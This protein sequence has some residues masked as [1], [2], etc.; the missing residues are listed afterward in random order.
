MNAKKNPK[1][2]LENKKS[3]FFQTGIILAMALSLAAFQWKV[4][5]RLIVELPNNIVTLHDDD[6]IEITI[7]KPPP[8]PPVQPSTELIITP[9]APDDEPVLF[10]PEIDIHDIVEHRPA[11]IVPTIVEPTEPEPTWFV[12]IKPEYPGGDAALFRYFGE[13]IRYPVL[14]RETG[15]KGTVFIQFVIERDGSVTNVQIMKG[16]GG[17]CDEEAMRVIKGMQRWKPGIKDGKPAR[18]LFSVP[19]TFRLQ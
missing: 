15:I 14:A 6:L 2:D 19:V 17:G 16:I 18:T 10:N 3:M 7:P 11:P 13:N 9:D 5:E 4:S 8:P 1:K 12:D